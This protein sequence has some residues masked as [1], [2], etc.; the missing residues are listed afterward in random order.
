MLDFGCSAGRILRFFDKEAADGVEVWGCDIDATSMEWC[1][2]S[3]MPPLSSRQI[4]TTQP[5]LPFPDRH[6]DSI[7]A[8]SVFSHMNELTTAWLLELACLTTQ[9]GIPE[10]HH[11]Q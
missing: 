3:L 4:D 5:H 8:G 11:P 1:Q 9:G 2:R 10:F 7:Y 6:F